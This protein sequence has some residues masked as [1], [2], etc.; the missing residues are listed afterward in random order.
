MGSN[1]Q[2]RKEILEK[3][4]EAEERQAQIKKCVKEGISLSTLDF[5]VRLDTKNS[6]GQK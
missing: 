5:V 3:V 1:T 2:K 6:Y 4:R